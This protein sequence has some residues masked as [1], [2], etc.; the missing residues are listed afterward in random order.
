MSLRLEREVF[1]E[2]CELAGSAIHPRRFKKMNG[3]FVTSF[4]TRLHWP[5]ARLRESG[6]ASAALRCCNTGSDARQ[7]QK[8]NLTG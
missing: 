1:L 6:S 7:Q 3:C 4:G 8:W 5:V 2:H